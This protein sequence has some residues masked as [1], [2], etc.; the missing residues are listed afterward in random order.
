MLISTNNHHSKGP[1]MSMDWY[2][3]RVKPI[4]DNSSTDDLELLT[5]DGMLS[6]AVVLGSSLSLVGLVFAFIT[7]R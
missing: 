1:T 4:Q 5:E 7:Y 6:L 2:L 3:A